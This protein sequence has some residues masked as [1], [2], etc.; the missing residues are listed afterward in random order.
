MKSKLKEEGTSVEKN[1]DLLNYAY[2]P[3]LKR[4]KDIGTIK[5][6]G[7]DGKHELFLQKLST[8]ERALFSLLYFYEH[9]ILS[10]GDLYVY[11]VFYHENKWWRY[12]EEALNYF[13]LPELIYIVETIKNL[14]MVDRSGRNSLALYA[15]KQIH[16][17]FCMEKHRNYEH[18]AT[19]V[20]QNMDDFS[21]LKRMKRPFKT[22]F[23]TIVNGNN[24]YADS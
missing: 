19:I 15:F 7:L 20:K 5:Y 9:A 21:L 16:A 2:K 24:K 23:D 22:R 17:E 3:L 8:G 12:L 18:I 14:L 6:Q 4:F 13:K 10:G 11:S 1:I